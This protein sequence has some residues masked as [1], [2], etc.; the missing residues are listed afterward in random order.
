MGQGGL[1][2]LQDRGDVL[3]LG[4]DGAEQRGGVAI[5]HV[6][7]EFVRVH[8]L[9]GGLGL[10]PARDAGQVESFHVDGELAVHGCGRQLHRDLGVEGFL[11]FS[12]EFHVAETS[13]SPSRNL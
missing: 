3:G 6:A 2:G 9:F 12:G 7:D 8:L 11:E 10:E 4:G 13:R 5:Q 1:E